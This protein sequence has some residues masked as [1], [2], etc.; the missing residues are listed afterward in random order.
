MRSTSTLLALFALVA[1]AHG[2]D[3]LSFIEPDSF[4][5]LFDM[6]EFMMPP[7]TVG[8]GPHQGGG[9]VC[10]DENLKYCTYHFNEKLNV[11]NA[12][13]R[14]P[15][16][17]WLVF[18]A[19]F[20]KGLD[21]G[22]IPLCSAYTWFYGCLGTQYKDCMNRN[23]I[24][25]RGYTYSNATLYTQL[26]AQLAF[27]CDAGSI[28]TTQSWDC[29]EKERISVNYQHTRDACLAAFNKGTNSGHNTSQICNYGQ[30]LVQCLSAPFIA[31]KKNSVV[32]WDC[33]LSR[34]S[35]NID[36]YC[37]QISCD[38]NVHISSNGGNSTSLH[39]MVLNSHAS[40][41]LEIMDRAAKSAAKR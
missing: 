19:Y 34:A 27:M 29:I 1:C 33:E 3:K 35:F 18:E 36:G 4:L 9:S 8:G 5:N 23:S 6:P 40:K 17:L 20:K 12:D 31:C 11:T 26:F 24:I 2:T 22:V 13:W 32:W 15:K 25:R 14:N 7:V 30:T 21:K 39:E 38:Y 28:E 16:G 41:H 10:A 37:P